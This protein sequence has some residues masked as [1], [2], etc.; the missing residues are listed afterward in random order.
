[1]NE[2]LHQQLMEFVYGLL[3]EDEANA[4]CDRI[5][6]DPEAARAYAK[7]KLQCDLVGRAARIDTPKVAWI[8]PDEIDPPS[9]DLRAASSDRSAQSYRKLANWCIGAAASG[10]ICL[11]ASTYWLSSRVPR[12]ES[13]PVAFASAT[14]VQVVL[15]GP[16]KLHSEASNPFSIRVENQAGTPVST[17]LEYRVYDVT[18]T[19]SWQNSTTTD[20]SGVARFDVE[21]ESAR[22]A[23]RLEVTAA[24]GSPAP[25]VRE[26]EAAPER[27]VTYLRMDRP[28]YQPGERLFYRSLTLSQFGLRAE[29]DVAASFEIV[30]ANDEPLDGAANVVTTTQGVGSG[31]VALP[32]DLPDGKYTLI[33]RSP[34]NLFR[35]EWRD[36]QVRRY[37]PPLL[38]KKLELARD[39][40]TLG[41]Q[42]NVDFYPEGGDLAAGLPS[43]VYF[44][45]RDPLG[46]P[47]HVEGRIVDSNGAVMT[48]VVTSHEGRG[49][50]SFTPAAGER[51][52][53]MIDK[54][55]GVTNEVPLPVASSE[56]FA[57]LETGEGV[58]AASAPV[59][60]ALYQRT[61]TKPLLVA[62]YCRGAM[63]AQQTID[64]GDYDIE[65]AEYATFR[66]E[67]GLPA[68]AQGVIR[69]TVFDGTLTPP[70]PIAERLV[71]R[72]V[73]QQ[74]A[75]RFAPD[76]ET[77]DPGQSVQLDLE[78]RDER[79]AP[80]PAVLG[81]AIVDDAV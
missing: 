20:E 8:R 21:G 6:S 54:P 23:A 30:N 34:D 33:A 43:R 68:E 45:G 75:V 42:V 50:F 79:D 51:Y 69:L 64:P 19:V 24:N 81:I 47:T 31:A 16:S 36:F 78:V 3:E 48:D 10:L 5:T 2:E 9:S 49:L 38:L 73:G 63:V 32:S 1:M 53:L 70:V 17:T 56:R 72:R 41:D 28:L 58:F 76:T 18:G 74:L 7:V 22:H 65:N 39:S 12:R 15:T 40:Y 26:L 11:V 59:T 29:K 57:M 27:F 37:K 35:E 46:K 60:F 25:I 77:F 52:R 4:L 44:H 67:L 80:V 66:G 61:P 62:A 55:V 14:P 71:Y 13:T